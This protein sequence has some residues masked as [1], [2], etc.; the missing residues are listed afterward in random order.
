MNVLAITLHTFEADFERCVEAVRQQTH[1][2]IEHICFHNLSRNESNRALYGTFMKRAD[3]FDLMIRIDADMVI[4]EPTLI[5]QMVEQFENN[6]NHDILTLYIHD[7]YTDRMISGMHAFRNTVRWPLDGEIDPDGHKTPRER[8]L[9]DRDRLGRFVKHGHGASPLEAMQFGIHRGV[10]LC[11]W[12]V[13]QDRRRIFSF[14]GILDALWHNL[15]R[16][17]DRRIALAVVGA[18]LGLRGYFD[19]RHLSH[20]DP[21]PGHVLAQLEGFDGQTM[22]REAAAMRRAS[23]GWLPTILRKRALLRYGIAENHPLPDWAQSA[24]AALER[25]S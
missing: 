11:N 15:R 14:T 12:I 16:C 3:E 25:P 5:A 7:F 13:Q 19:N 6:P 20:Q 8:I 1:Q 18:E 17:R 2:P 9:I 4:T 10:K 21:L 24:S 23:W 22:M